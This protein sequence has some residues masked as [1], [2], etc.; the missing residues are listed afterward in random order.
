MATSNTAEKRSQAKVVE[1]VPS[2]DGNR[3]ADGWRAGRPI[4]DPDK[5]KKWG[6]VTAKPSEYLICVKNGKINRRASGQGARIFK[7]PWESVAIVP[8]TLQRIEFVADQ[9]TLEKIGVRVS[10]IA[11]FRI[12]EPEIAYRVLN[13]TFGEAASEK[14]NDTLCEMFI[15]SARR[16]IANLSLDE[17]LTKRKEAIATFLMQE[18]APVV[19]GRGSPDDTTDRGWGVVIDT[20]E[21]Q[22]VKI[23]SDKVFNDLQA[24]Y[25]NALA[26]T[27]ETAELERQRELAERRAETERRVAQA[28]IDGDR[29]T[30]MLRAQAEAQATET[31]AAEMLRADQAKAKLAVEDLA[32]KEALARRRIE[33]E[34]RVA[35]REAERAAAIER[36]AREVERERELAQIAKDEEKRR[37]AAQ[38]E[39]NA[40]VSEAQLAEQSH[41]VAA[42]RL[43]QERQREAFTLETEVQLRDARVRLELEL[44]RRDADVKR[45]ENSIEAERALAM[46]EV[47]QVSGQARAMSELVTIGLPNI[48]QAFKQSFGTVNYTHLGGGGSGDDNPL[49]MVAGMFA[50]VLAVAKSFGLDPAKFAPSDETPKK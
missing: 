5:L 19:S 31:E 37:Y 35:L 46:A 9:I 6:F 27:A 42:R 15:G 1:L 47:D 34:E 18:I 43:E 38:A 21:I 45:F 36:N 16:L 11:V 24:A 2:N 32:R 50:Q 33:G 20:I 26:T 17:C 40:L 39:Q 48:A 29:Q 12:A 13:F 49:G 8:T 25:R 30:R 28:K 7:W 14:L 44:R 22:D 23:Q 3:Y 4:E 10:G 41:A